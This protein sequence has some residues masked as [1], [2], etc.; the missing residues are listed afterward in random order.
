MIRISIVGTGNVAKHLFH[1]LQRNPELEVSE[2]LGRNREKLKFFAQSVRTK[3]DFS[4]AA[5]ADVYLIAVSDD[6]IVQVANSLKDKKG[7]LAH[8]SGSVELEALPSESRK[9]VFYPL[10]SFSAN[11]KVNFKEVPI[12]IEAEYS[13]DYELLEYIGGSIS[14]QVVRLSSKERRALHL[15]AVFVNNFN[16]HLYQIGAAICEAQKLPF[17]LLHPLIRES[18][19]KLAQLSPYNA[20]TGPAR[21]G[22]SATVDQHLRLLKDPLHKEVYSLLSNSI[23]QTYGK[24]L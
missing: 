7:I 23:A 17:S 16:N 1:T 3:S 18:A 19:E 24:K 4:T 13:E 12:C 8:S 6:A 9:G 10:Q 20:Q 14:G 2:V 5:E 15:A 21:R 11:R 22:D